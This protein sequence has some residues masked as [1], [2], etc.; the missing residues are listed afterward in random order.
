MTDVERF[1]P[2]LAL[3]GGPDGLGVVR[4]LV[5]QAA[6]RAVPWL[7]LEIGL[8]Q[9][10]AVAELCRS[11]RWGSVRIDADLAGIGRVVVAWR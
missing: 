1:E 5:A 8:G 9:A 11:A 2:A 6:E 7:A 3:R 10:D 4:Q